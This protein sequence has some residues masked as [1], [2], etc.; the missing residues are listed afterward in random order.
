[1]FPFLLHVNQDQNVT[2]TSSY[3][4]CH[5]PA[6]HSA[7]SRW[8]AGPHQVGGEVHVMVVTVSRDA[9]T[10]GENFSATVLGAPP[11]EITP[12]ILLKCEAFQSR[13]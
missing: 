4:H 11:H 8:G 9:H 3:E 5:D 1:M 6:H 10:Y 2:T 12:L 7:P 13:A